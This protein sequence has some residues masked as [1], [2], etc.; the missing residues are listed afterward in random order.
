MPLGIELTAEHG[1]LFLK[2]TGEVRMPD[3]VQALT[4]RLSAAGIPP[5]SKVLC[6]VTDAR[7]SLALKGA[8]EIASLL[9]DR[10]AEFS[11]SRWAFVVPDAQRFGVEQMLKKLLTGAPLDYHAFTETNRALVWLG[12]AA[13]PDTATS[14]DALTD[15]PI[16]TH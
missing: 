6:D 12:I 1:A 4:D 16:A 9:R 15:V 13:L 7:P 11:H 5:P 3:L 10:A 8:L 2:I 14:R